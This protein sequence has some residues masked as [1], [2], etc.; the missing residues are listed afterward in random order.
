MGTLVLVAV[1]A[2]LVQPAPPD[3]KLDPDSP[4]TGLYLYRAHCAVCHGK[5]GEGDGPLA[6]QLRTVPPDL[7]RLAAHGGGRFRADDV[8]RVIDGRNPLK[9]HGGPEMPVWGSAFKERASSYS[10]ARS[11]ERIDKVV[12]YLESIQAR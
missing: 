9:G 7:T 1:V 2:V 8:A 6:D 11:Q 5:T 3:Q 10:E 12:R 4:E